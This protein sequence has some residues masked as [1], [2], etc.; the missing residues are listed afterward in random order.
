MRQFECFKKNEIDNIAIKNFEEEI[1]C[2]EIFWTFIV[3]LLASRNSVVYN[4]ITKFKFNNKHSIFLESQ[5]LVPVIGLEGNS[6]LDMALGA[7]EIRSNT[8]SGIQFNQKY[9]KSVCFVEAKYLSD[10]SVMTKHSPLRNQMDRVIENLLCFQGGNKYPEEIIFTLLTPRLFKTN[11]GARLYS[12]KFEEYNNELSKRNLEFFKKVM[13]D[14]GTKRTGNWSY[15]SDIDQRISCLKLNWVT[16]EEIFE[17]VYPEF[18]N[19]SILN[20]NQAHEIWMKITKDLNI[21]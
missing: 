15:P 1:F 16:F 2:N 8:I 14:S 6:H 11:K 12:Y 5:P 4:K 9:G 19:Y 21:T 10:L 13:L 18:M 3:A 20:K 17:T 7:I